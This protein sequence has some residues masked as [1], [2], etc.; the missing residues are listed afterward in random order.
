[1]AAELQCRAA[2][3][4]GHRAEMRGSLPAASAIARLSLDEV[5]ALY[6]SGSVPVDFESRR[7]PDDTRSLPASFVLAIDGAVIP[8]ESD[9]AVPRS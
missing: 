2:R 7:S 4:L 8:T 1:M 5:E 9:H 6:R 3:E